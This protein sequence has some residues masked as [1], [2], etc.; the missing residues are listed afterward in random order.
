MM[1]AKFKAIEI[2]YRT[3]RITMKGVKE[4]VVKGV[5]TQEQCDEILASK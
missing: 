1:N 5:I 4:A 2:L 3:N